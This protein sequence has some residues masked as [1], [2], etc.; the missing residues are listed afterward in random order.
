MVLVTGGAGFIGSHTCVE[1][2]AKNYNIVIVDD[3]SNSSIDTI[4][5]I[6]L[7]AKKD[8]IFYQIDI[9]DN[10][11]LRQLFGRYKFDAVI[12]F[13]GYKAVGESLKKPFKYYFNNLYGTMML[14][15][16]MS[17][18][19]VKKLIF[20]SS[21]TVYG[22]SKAGPI[23]EDFSTSAVNPY[24]E[25]KLFVE[26]YLEKIKNDDPEWNIVI[27][28]YFN[29]I[30]AHESG[31]IGE[32]PVGIPNNLMPYLLKVA[33][34]EIY[35]LII[36]GDDYRTKD[37][38]GVRDFIHVTDLAIA[39]ISSLNLL[40]SE[41]LK[42]T[43]VY[44]IN[45]GT[46]IGYSVFELV[47]AFK[48]YNNVSIPYRISKRRPGDSA[49]S[50]ADPSYAKEVIGWTANKNLKDMCQDSWRWEKNRLKKKS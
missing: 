47:N 16:V 44:K 7:I 6:E 43:E 31:L 1:L 19:G 18:F 35:E 42:K 33:S 38:T 4:N 41:K 17:F 22:E 15:D 26:Q 34:K 37:G 11:A 48:K 50:F 14:C 24:G 39:H 28:R 32:E 46:G 5:N 29:P 8:I 23:K 49:E 12:H 27:L 40:A 10:R 3:L 25:S 13:A 21:A 2:L 30:G 9:L 36:F 20:S 45:I